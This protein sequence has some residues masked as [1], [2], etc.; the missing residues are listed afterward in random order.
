MQHKITAVDKILHVPGGLTEKHHQA[1]DQV[2][3]VE[4]FSH[5]QVCRIVPLMES[6]PVTVGYVYCFLL[7]CGLNFH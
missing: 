2:I 6:Q 4:Q 7:W 5:L 3:L 1:V